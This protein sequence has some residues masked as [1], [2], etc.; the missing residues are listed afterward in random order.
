MVQR[1]RLRRP[2]PRWHASTVDRSRS[3][4]HRRSPPAPGVDRNRSRRVRQSRR[5]RSRL[6]DADRRPRSNDERSAGEPPSPQRPLG[7]WAITPVGRRLADVTGN[8]RTLQLSF[9][10]NTNRCCDCRRGRVEYG[11]RSL[12]PAAVGVELPQPARRPRRPEPDDDAFSGGATDDRPEPL[13]GPHDAGCFGRFWFWR[14]CH[15]GAWAGSARDV[16]VASRRHLRCAW[17]RRALLGASVGVAGCAG[18]WVAVS[19]RGAA[20][21]ASGPGGALRRAFGGCAGRD[22]RCSRRAGRR[23]GSRRGVA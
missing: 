18:G 20:G 15:L 7:Q 6:S 8:R 23:G 10:N 9:P 2:S 11:Y 13:L 17:R 19:G 16:G 12:T 1:F 3:P 14:C 5:N 4:R 21:G 22:G